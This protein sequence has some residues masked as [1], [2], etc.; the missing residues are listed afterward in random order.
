MD[1]SL[2]TQLL[3]NQSRLDQSALKQVNG[4]NCMELGGVWIDEGF[5]AKMESITVKAQSK[6]KD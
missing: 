4:R 6:P 5:N 3:R 1:L 2:Q